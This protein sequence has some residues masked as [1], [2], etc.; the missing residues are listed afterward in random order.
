MVIKQ[1][2][3]ILTL[4]LLLT[5]LAGETLKSQQA[6]PLDT[7]MRRLLDEKTDT[8][9]IMLYYRIAHELQYSEPEKSK[10]YAERAYNESLKSGFEKGTGNALI[11]LGNIEQIKGNYADA[12][13]YNLKALDILRKAGDRAGE[14]ICYNNLG[15]LLHNRNDYDNA[16]QYYRKSLDINNKI[17][18]KAGS[19]TSLFCIGTVFENQLAYDSALVYYLRGQAIS[20]EIMDLKLMA[21]AKTSLA[22]VYFQMGNYSR[23][24]QYNEEAVNLFSKAKNDY[25]LLK[26]YLTLGQ[27]AEMLDSTSRAEWFYRQAGRIG[28]QLQSIEDIANA[29]FYMA[30]LFENNGRPDSALVYYR[31]AGSYF[32]QTGNRENRSFSLTALARLLN[33]EKKHREA[34]KNLTEALTIAGEISSPSAYLA[35]SREMAL[36]YSYL[37]DFRKAFNWFNRYSDARD[38]IMDTE[39][40]KQILE[41]QT[42]YETEKK[43]NENTLLKKDLQIQKSARNSLIIG[44]LLLILLVIVIFRSLAIKKRDNKLLLEQKEEIQRQK[45]VVEYQKLAITDSIRYAKRIQTAMLP[46]EGLLSDLIP[47]SFILYLP[48]DIVSGDFYWIRKA[49]DDHILVCAADCTGHGV[50]GAFMSM[51]GMSLI[52]D[53]INRNIE[54][55]TCGSFTP[56]DILN[57]LRNRIKLSLRQTGKEGE[58]RD[59]MDMAVCLIRMSDGNLIYAGA[60]NPVYFVT[61]GKLTELKGTRNPVGIYP[62]EME[63]V[64]NNATIPKGSF[65]YLFSDGYFDQ[66]GSEGGKYLSKRFKSLLSS[67]S[68]LSA[69]EIREKLLS[70]HLQWRKDAEQVD[71]ILVMGLKI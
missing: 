44:A 58:S 13:S 30:Q 47:D 68:H 65:L 37:N 1:I 16:I 52:S 71:D 50:P 32:E 10:E 24:L 29:D 21:Y 6:A 12:E 60:I 8:G 34:E 43:E 17:N 46:P 35:A 14:A 23:A 45:E 11:Q 57:E 51:L 28:K 31:N 2:F 64:N 5:E 40:Q 18:R 66:I 4:S 19:A 3:R 9:R 56:A 53:I 54:R 59:A 63:F 67:I 27:T 38:S 61:D 49:G 33:G 7:L 42:R 41:L 70:E 48:R 62:N 22:N 36:T 69:S 15:I 25:G 20:E 55:L 39:K 26:V